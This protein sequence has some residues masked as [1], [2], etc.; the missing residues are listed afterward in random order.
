MKIS[1]ASKNPIKIDA[2]RETIKSYPLLQDSEISNIEVVSGVS[3][4]PRS[5]EETVQ[6]AMNRAKG[7]F[8]D[9]TY[10]FGIESGFMQ[11]PNT[12][13]GFMNFTVC[14]IYD[15][16]RYHIGLS[17]AFECPPAITRM[18]FDE[19]LDI[20]QAYYKTGL[21]KDEKVGYSEGVIS[22]LTKGRLIRK[23]H[24]KEAV[25]MALIH[26]ENAE[27]YKD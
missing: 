13:T 24:T 3:E 19:N 1:I 2:V 10:S 7:A 20:N 25:R 11:V 27:L 14:V 23:D 22:Y 17:S 6:G 21:T 8:R 9:C 26:L 4:Q 12:K 18:V 16:S 15:G 5:L